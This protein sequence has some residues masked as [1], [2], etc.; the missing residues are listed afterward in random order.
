MWCKR[1]GERVEKVVID[2]SY[3]NAEVRFVNAV[4]VSGSVK[5]LPGV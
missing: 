4:T 1:E 2:I 3:A 5:F